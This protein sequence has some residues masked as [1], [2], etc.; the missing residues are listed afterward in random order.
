VPNIFEQYAAEQQQPQSA[1]AGN[2]F[3]QYAA[4]RDAEIS[5]R[6]AANPP[7]VP[8]PPLPA[9]LQSDDQR[10][11]AAP[12]VTDPKTGER[13]QQTP[14]GLGTDPFTKLL[15]STYTGS[16]QAGEG[17][18]QMAQP[19][20]REKAGGLHKVISGVFEAATPLIAGAGVVAPAATA[21][22]LAGTMAAQTGVEA[23]L[24]KIG[25]AP[26]YA[27]VTGD[28]T[29]LVAGAAVHKL[30]SGAIDWLKS[31]L[32]ERLEAKQQ[33]AGPQYTS[34][35]D[36][37]PPS[38]EEVNQRVTQNAQVIVA[39]AKAPA[40]AP[41]APVQPQPAPIPPAPQI[42]EE[43]LPNHATTV[44]QQP[45]A[46]QGT[47]AEAQPQ[48][49]QEAEPPPAATGGLVTGAQPGV[50][51]AAESQGSDAQGP[52]LETKPAVPETKAAV[53]ETKAAVPEVD[54]ELQKLREEIA[55]SP[56]VMG[57]G[58]LV[59]YAKLPPD[60]QAKVD[61]LANG[62]MKPKETPP[63]APAQPPVTAAP[64]PAAQQNQ[65][66]EPALPPATV[67]ETPQS[68]PHGPIRLDYDGKSKQWL[69]T[70]YDPKPPATEGILDG[71]GNPVSGAGGPTS[72]PT[73]DSV[74]PLSTGGTSIVSGAPVSGSG[75]HPSPNSGAPSSSIASDEGE[76]NSKV[77]IPADVRAASE[78]LKLRLGTL[79]KGE[80]GEQK[81]LEDW[82]AQDLRDLATVSGHYIRTAAG[83]LHQWTTAMVEHFGEAIRPYL[84]HAY[85]LGK[86]EVDA[87][88]P[89]EAPPQPTHDEPADSVYFGS[90][91]GALEPFFREAK[92]EGDRLRLERSAAL[93]AMT[94]ARE[95]PAEEHAG[96]KF[97]AWYN[98]ELDLWATRVN[99]AIDT[100]NRVTYRTPVLR[101][102]GTAAENSVRLGKNNA[103]S[104]DWAVNEREAVGIMRQFRHIPGELQQFIDGTHPDFQEIDGGPAQAVKNLKVVVPRMRE[105]LAMMARPLTKTENVADR[106]YTSIADKTLKEGL[107]V[108]NIGGSRWK[109][110]VYVPQLLNPK[111]E[112][113]VAKP[114]STRG[115]VMG[116]QI[117]KFFGFAERREFPTILHAIAAGY[118]PKTLDPSTAFII[119]GHAFARSRATHLAEKALVDWRMGHWGRGA[120]EGWK[121]L[122]EHADEFLRLIPFIREG[123]AQGTDAAAQDVAAR[124]IAAMQN[125]QTYR[126]ASQ[127][128]VETTGGPVADVA[129]QRLYVAPFIK[130]AMSALTDP[131][132]NE[133]YRLNLHLW[134][135]RGSIGY[136]EIRTAQRELKRAIL[137]FS[138]YHLLT[139]NYMAAADIGPVGMWRA[140]T[141]PL[142][143]PASLAAE[144][145]LIGV[146]GTTSIEGQTMD[147]YRSLK[148]GTIPTRAE[149]VR[150]YIPLV[151]QA[152]AAAD[153]ITRFTF[154]NIQ[155]RFKITSFILWRDAWMRDNPVASEDQ[156]HEAMKGIASYVNGVYGGLHWSNMGISRAMVEVGRLI[157]LAP[158]WTGSNLALAK[159]AMDAPMSAHEIPFAKKLSGTYTKE[160]TQ[161]RLSRA[162]WT[163]QIVGGMA[164]TIAMSLMFS[165]PDSWKKWRPLQV[166]L[167]KD[168]EGKDVY[169]NVFFRGSAGD[170]VSLV[171]RMWK[172]GWEGYDESG[173]GGALVGLGLGVGDF[174]GSKASP[175][176][177]FGKHLTG[178]NDF[179]R[180][181][182]ATDLA[183]DVLPIPIFARTLYDDFVENPEDVEWSERMLSLFSPP[184]QHVAP[185][186]KHT[187]HRKPA[188]KKPPNTGWK[189]MLLGK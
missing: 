116:G 94:K 68:G 57:K 112:G 158:D 20:L 162:F 31:R 54:P 127:N 132:F 66:P 106:L 55:L 178:R 5:R 38:P 128:E 93:A 141:T 21:A 50:Q 77:E 71:S 152:L 130:A 150:A 142:E 154:E 159:Y 123:P 122:A 179:G 72:P 65:P 108:G 45:V 18:A 119:H 134:K 15:D 9:G 100:L 32:Q 97:R 39:A 53:P 48:V 169:Q 187:T 59:A 157:F 28:L 151:N 74:V 92:K 61:R 156:T 120:P 40:P 160:S 14:L 175:F 83:D 99:Q 147:A 8:S 124:K 88:T 168:K 10:R 26:E 144:R 75:E 27:A 64:E 23:G 186:G 58:K 17:V 155:R 86:S 165:G 135:W 107:R 137:G 62:I 136:S 91:L 164:A 173:A 176:G 146:G 34:T 143:S 6:M 43:T 166:Y 16:Q 4:Q 60:V 3:E 148:P 110:D 76:V 111:G 174:A 19:E 189:K 73:G 161:A 149:V 98:A 184:A 49:S 36:L 172:H 69:V 33:A 170:L 105:A 35:G 96:E 90:G 63:A 78:R 171:S 22:T 188:H 129:E 115:R 180:K 125:G 185:A 37:I 133:R 138:A 153:A 102:I 13:Y 145:E 81:P 56:D 67:A 42:Q 87:A 177:K 30:G 117:G 114:P 95:T 70:E 140:F 118:I 1:P 181:T 113:D 11:A 7:G 139:E 79:L 104:R 44:E 47:T 131:D 2:I 101:T 183:S 163:K 89:P 85:R 103:G 51:Q 80:S 12:L 29:A 167:G 52:L 25:L 109:P 24:K 82:D 41:A 182:T 121:P 84:E 46:Q 126:E